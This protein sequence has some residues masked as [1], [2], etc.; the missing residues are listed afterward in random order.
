MSAAKRAR[1]FEPG[2]TYVRS[3][4]TDIRKLFERVR[5]ELGQLPAH[6]ANVTPLQRKG[7]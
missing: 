5:R 4:A 1:C 3:E 2:W 7:K 6:Q